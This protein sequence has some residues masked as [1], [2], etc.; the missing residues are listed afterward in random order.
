MRFYDHLKEKALAKLSKAYNAYML[1][2][3]ISVLS[4]GFNSYSIKRII[5]KLS[6][7]AF[8]SQIF[9]RVLEIDLFWMARVS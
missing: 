6:E 5:V 8:R 3:C 1:C 4:D 9:I 7:A 2:M